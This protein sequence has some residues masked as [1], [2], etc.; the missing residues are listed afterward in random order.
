MSA[1]ATDSIAI[2]VADW[3]AHVQEVAGESF[4][5][6]LHK[7][8]T[9][10]CGRHRHAG[11]AEIMLV[12]KGPLQHILNGRKQTEERGHLILIRE[13]DVHELRGKK[14][15]YINLA[16]PLRWFT[17]LESLWEAPGFF[18]SLLSSEVTPR[19]HVTGP[20]LVRLE[21][22]L[23]RIFTA[24]R[25]VAARH[26]FAHFLHEVLKDSFAAFL[27]KPNDAARQLPEWLRDTKAWIDAQPMHQVTIA[28]V[29]KRAGRCAE[30][31]SRSF[32]KYFGG[33][34]SDYLNQRRLEGAAAHLSNSNYPITEV[35]LAAGFENLSYFCRL[36]RRHYKLSPRD[37]RRKHQQILLPPRRHLLPMTENLARADVRKF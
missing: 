3:K 1:S 35:S 14:V 9:A 24:R 25:G 27:A 30:H 13:Q 4:L 15:A 19:V 34:L 21:K 16:F 36:F 26:L 17:A 18:E 29:Y 37:Y 7:G 2:G 28:A 33:T 32:R 23:Q 5:L 10:Q 11:M 31:I 20:Q 8:K 6:E 22:L 12:Q